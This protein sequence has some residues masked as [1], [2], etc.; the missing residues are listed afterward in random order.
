MQKNVIFGPAFWAFPEMGEGGTH[1]QIFV[2]VEQM[3]LF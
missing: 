3:I 1:A 2:Q